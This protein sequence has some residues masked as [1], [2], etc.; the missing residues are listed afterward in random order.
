MLFNADIWQHFTLEE[1][2]LEK[3]KYAFERNFNQKVGKNYA[4]QKFRL[5]L[6]EVNQLLNNRALLAVYVYLFVP[7][8]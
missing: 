5:I 1:I 6:D 3:Q 4:K 7:S 8:S 2:T